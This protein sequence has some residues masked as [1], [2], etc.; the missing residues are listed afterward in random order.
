MMVGNKTDY[1]TKSQQLSDS[2]CKILER[3]IKGIIL[4]L[5]LNGGGAMHPMI[6]GVE[7]L[8][9]DGKVGAFHTNTT[10]YWYIRNHRFYIDSIDFAAIQ[11]KCIVDATR[12]PVI[13]LVSPFTGSSAECLIIAFKGRKNTVL[14]GSNSA[15]YVTI[16]NGF[17]INDT[18][19]LNLSVGYSADRSG[20][21]Y[22]AAIPPDIPFEATDSFNDL[23]TDE[24]VKAAIKWI[25]ERQ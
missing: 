7:A 11:P 8:L 20:K 1:Y 6:L 4:D 12:I 21:I 19:F 9:G 18:A 5:R 3:P 25:T 2:L 14:L 16:N 13:M 24:K 22:K 10:E 23:L 17:Q 15:G